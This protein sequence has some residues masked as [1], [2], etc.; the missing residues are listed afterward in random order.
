MGWQN[1]EKNEVDSM[2]VLKKSKFCSSIVQTEK[3]S[4]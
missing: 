2:P 3:K 1:Y 4:K